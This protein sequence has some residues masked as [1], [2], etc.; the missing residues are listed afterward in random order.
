MP[1]KPSITIILLGDIAAGKAT[2]SGYLV[3]RYGCRELDM[4]RELRRMKSK[5]KR[6]AR[7]LSGTMDKGKLAQTEVVRGIF[8]DFILGT[9]KSKGL[10]LD[11][12]PKM[13]GEA[14][15]VRAWL[16]ESGRGRD[17][18]LVLYLKITKAEMTRRTKRRQEKEGRTDDSAA[19]I[20]NRIKYYQKNIAAVIAYFEK[21][22]TYKIVSSM[23]T[24][25]Q[26]ERN[27][28]REV[29]GFLSKKTQAARTARK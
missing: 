18:V 9:P 15:L 1:R 10:L 7:A 8:R 12:A 4:G 23:G 26:V 17:S 21:H 28:E 16:E 5:D 25:A 11:G 24:I 20:A 6:M 27:I 22:Y 29:N 2:H 13:V 3:R 14:R 19:A